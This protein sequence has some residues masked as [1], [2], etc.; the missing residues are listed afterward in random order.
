MIISLL[1]SCCC[2]RVSVRMQ[3]FG[4]KYPASLCGAQGGGRGRRSG[5]QETEGHS[6][7]ILGSHEEDGGTASGPVRRLV[8]SMRQTHG[9]ALSSVGGDPSSG[10]G[11]RRAF[12]R[13]GSQEARGQSAASSA[14]ASKDYFTRRC[15]LQPAAAMP[16]LACSCGCFRAGQPPSCLVYPP[17]PRCAPVSAASRV[18]SC[19]I[20]RA[21]EP[22]SLP[23][24]FRGGL[25]LGNEG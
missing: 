25:S 16:S 3:P 24:A 23:A 11:Q 15:A 2:S 5:V 7:A 21:P 18:Y 9:S 17:R 20:P 13:H 8:S 4:E 12:I 6:R 22:E 1:F 19:K 10:P 14:A